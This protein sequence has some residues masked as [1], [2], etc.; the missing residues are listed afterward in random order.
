MIY[1]SMA[2]QANADIKIKKLLSKVV[3]T[4]R[5]QKLNAVFGFM[6]SVL[7]LDRNA[8]AQ[9]LVGAD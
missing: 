3:A 2:A 1:E 8:L 4:N 5:T 6:F 7:P 9:G